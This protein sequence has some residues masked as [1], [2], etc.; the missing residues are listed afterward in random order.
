MVLRERFFVRKERFDVLL[1]LPHFH[2]VTS[3]YKGIAH[4][5]F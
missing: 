1:A 4:T 3:S 2:D 5:H